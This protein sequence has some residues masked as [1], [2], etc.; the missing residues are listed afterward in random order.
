VDARATTL[1]AGGTDGGQ[2]YVLND[3][4]RKKVVAYLS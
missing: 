2:I 1:R 3:T 4:I